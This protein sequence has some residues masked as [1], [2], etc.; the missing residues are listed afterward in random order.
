MADP[1]TLDEFHLHSEEK[2][3]PFAVLLFSSLQV[4]RYPQMLNPRIRK[5]AVMRKWG[6]AV[7]LFYGILVLV[8]AVPSA[9][10]LAGNKG[11]LSVGFYEEVIEFYKQVWTWIPIACLLVGQA[12]LFFLSVDTAYKRLRPRA[13][14]VVSCLVTAMLLGL[15]TVAGILSLGVAISSDKFLDRIPDNMGQLLGLW[16]APWAIW[17]ILFYVYL[18][19]SDNFTS[20]AISWL[21]RGSVLELLVAVPCHVMVRRRHDC[22]AP[23]AT[24]FGIATGI[25]VMLLSFGPGVLLLY[26]KRL[27][28]YSEYRSAKPHLV[29]K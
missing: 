9:V 21:L 17:A 15:L 29:A 11:L 1:A 24:G 13:H 10:V 25:A 5:N 3:K 6:I 20:R 27:A 26:K 12:I 14:I 16:A 28:T 22:S 18:R 4:L 7:S 2:V 8:F 19:T 23:I